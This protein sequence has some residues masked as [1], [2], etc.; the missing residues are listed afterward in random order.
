MLTP[1]EYRLSQKYARVS[2]EMSEHEDKKSHCQAFDRHHRQ[3]T[4]DRDKDTK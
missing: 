4:V 1:T 2:V 3:R